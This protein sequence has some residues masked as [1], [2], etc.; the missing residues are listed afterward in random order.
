MDA[1]EYCAIWLGPEL[2]GDQR[3]DSALTATYVSDPLEVP[4]A[5]VGAPKITLTVTSDAPSAQIAVRLLDIHPDGAATRITYG[6]LNLAHRNSHAAPEALVPGTAY[7]AALNL[8]HIAYQVPAGHRLAIAVSNTYWPLLWPSPKAATL[9]L[10]RGVL[11]VPVRASEL[12]IDECS[13]EPPEADAPWDIETLRE[14]KSSRTT[15]TDHVTGV[16]T[17]RVTDDFGKVRDL[18]HGLINGS[19]AREW[20]SI[21]PNDP[22]S[23]H[24]KCHWTDEIE[25]DDL[26]LRT[27]AR[28]EMWSD[29]KTF[30]LSARMQAF[31]NDI[32]I[33]DRTLNDEIDRD[34]I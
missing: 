4:R 11:S 17:L 7:E 29:E 6:V 33:F 10:S 5:I 2:P 1:G 13:F 23:A 25:R 14:A 9:T 26:V 19:I 31:E 34:H 22:L 18:D 24:G 32:C 15:T 16:V 20:W 8:D 27:E 28:C 12:S 21:H 3:R 30:F